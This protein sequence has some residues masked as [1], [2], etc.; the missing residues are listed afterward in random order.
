MQGHSTS[1]QFQKKNLNGSGG[2][3]AKWRVD[4]QTELTW[5]LGSAL[6]KKLSTSY[7]VH[8]WLIGFLIKIQTNDHNY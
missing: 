3:I 7:T 8:D 4:R 2:E 5:V 6:F 1:G